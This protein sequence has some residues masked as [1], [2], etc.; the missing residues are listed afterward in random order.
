[1]RA[2]S[3]LVEWAT[4]SKKRK[5]EDEMMERAT[6]RMERSLADLRDS[7]LALQQALEGKELHVKKMPS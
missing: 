1:M 7:N 4:G 5:M 3:G 6:T 2:L